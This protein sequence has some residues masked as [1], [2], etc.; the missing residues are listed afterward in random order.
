MALVRVQ[1]PTPTAPGPGVTDYQAILSNLLANLGATLDR[2]P[3]NGNTIPEGAVIVVG[4]VPYVADSATTITGIP[5]L[6]VVVEPSLDGSTA[7]AAFSTVL[8]GTWN[9]EYGG[10]YEPSGNLVIF[11]EGRAFADGEIDTM[12]TDFGIK[13]GPRRKI[14]TATE[15]FFTPGYETTVFITGTAAG[16]NGGSGGSSGN[17][18]SSGGGGGG[19]GGQG[20]NR[21]RHPITKLPDEGLI[22]TIGAVGSDTVISGTV[23]GELLRLKCGANGTA[24]STGTNSAGSSV[25]GGAGGPGGGGYDK[26]GNFAGNPGAGG[27]GGAGNSAGSGGGGGG[28]G[29]NGYD[30][31]SAGGGGNASGTSGGGGGGGKGGAGP[32]G[33]GGNGGNGCNAGSNSAQNGAA[34]TG[35]GCGGGGGGGRASNGN[36]GNGGAGSPAMIIVEW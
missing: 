34:A 6:Y 1:V 20:S 9:S 27:A 12:H 19:G 33:R 35:Y 29:I 31:T 36:T 28:G 15:T 7:T 22:V 25:P 11:D 17:A 4:N 18:H 13:A 32:F 24:G 5:N 23:S 10:Y 30:E 14:I 21:T 8:T 2:S 26:R 16:G 3:V